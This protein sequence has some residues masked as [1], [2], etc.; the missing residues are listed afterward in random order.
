MDA[1]ELLYGIDSSII[2]DVCSINAF[3]ER[4]PYVQSA[5]NETVLFRNL[6]ANKEFC[7]NFVLS[8]MDIANTCFSDDNLTSIFNEWNS[9]LSWCDNFFIK[10][11]EYVFKH[12]EEEFGLKG[13]KEK[14]TVYLEKEN[15][16]NITV[17]TTSIKI[18]DGCW[19]GFYYTDYPVTLSVVE[20]P[21]YKFVAWKDKNGEVVSTDKIVEIGMVEGGVDICAVF[22]K[23]E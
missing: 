7:K 2:G 9:D 8:F 23:E 13:T 4:G 19:E 1:M 5:V 16:G 21:G 15:S 20:N 3:S 22:E 11:D 17:N 10:R 12:L 14:L 6:K 18:S